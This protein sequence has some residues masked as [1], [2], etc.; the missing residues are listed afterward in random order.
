[1]GSCEALNQI[2]ND[3]KFFKWMMGM[4]GQCNLGYSSP[5][6]PILLF[7]R[8]Q[9]VK[10]IVSAMR[11]QSISKN[12]LYLCN[13]LARNLSRKI[14]RDGH[15]DASNADD[16]KFIMKAEFMKFVRYLDK[17]GTKALYVSCELGPTGKN[18]VFPV[19]QANLPSE[20]YS[21]NILFLIFF[22]EMQCFDKL[23]QQ[24]NAWSLSG[25][26][27]MYSFT[28]GVPLPPDEYLTGLFL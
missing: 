7:Y 6:I 14:M 27:Y 1:M 28:V 3:L 2:L 19:A 15:T 24:R 20:A 4:N 25:R 9:L 5:F 8:S 13:A 10:Y 18:N 17:T 21:R 11:R 12:V 16:A 23:L 22:A 26:A